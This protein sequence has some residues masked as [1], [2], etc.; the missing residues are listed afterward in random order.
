[1]SARLQQVAG[2]H[3]KSQPTSDIT[4]KIAMAQQPAMDRIVFVMNSILFTFH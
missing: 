2:E 3:L 4:K 1:M